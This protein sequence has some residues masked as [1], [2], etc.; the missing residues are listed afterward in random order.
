VIGE[1]EHV[2]NNKQTVRI[3]SVSSYTNDGLARATREIEGVSKRKER[4]VK[5]RVAI[6][7]C[8]E[9]R[10]NKSIILAYLFE[11]LV[12]FFQVFCTSSSNRALCAY[13]WDFHFMGFWQK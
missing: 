4:E 7:W 12:F 11:I 5:T 9:Y 2:E 6:E 13:H 8:K 3:Y 1:Y 10:L